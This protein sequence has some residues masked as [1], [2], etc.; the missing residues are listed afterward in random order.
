MIGKTLE[1]LDTPSLIIDLDRMEQNLK[2][3][4][5][6]ADSA[7]V[8]LRPHTK[9]H[10]IADIAHLQMEYGAK[11]ITV[12]KI[13]EAEAMAEQG[14]TD[15]FIA[16]QVVGEHK[17]TRLR[18]LAEKT[19]LRLA[20]DSI[21]HVQEL[22][23]FFGEQVPLEVMIEVDTGMHR[24]GVEPEEAL[25]LAGE[26][27]KG[28]PHIKLAG[29][30]THEGHTYNAA[31]R[32]HMKQIAL[33]AQQSVIELGRKIKENWGITCEISVGCTLGQLVGEVLP[34]ITEVRPGTYVFYDVGHAYYLGHDNSCAATVLATI[35]TNSGNDKVVAD[36]G[37]KSMTIDQRSSGVLKTEGYGKILQ[38]P[39]LVIKKLSDEHA[40]IQPAGPLNIGDRIQI[41][42]N[43]ICPTVNLY[44]Q[45]YGVRNGVVEKVFTIHARGRIQ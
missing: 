45:A 9:T 41:I 11:G 26:I 43:H 27:V 24:C 39:N 16:T 12:A 17:L 35:T 23:S 31:D 8:K 30:F 28:Y 5:Q 22:A 25:K 34:G 2:D 1:Q 6:F 36:T 13:G 32:E 15:I 10:K 29:V 21:Y 19:K 42:P 20:I 37:A 33:H 18:S 14:I 3:M 7:G 40:V 4:Q 44:D 38:H